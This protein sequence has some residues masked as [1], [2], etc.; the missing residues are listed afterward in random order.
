MET[1]GV[2]EGVV[3]FGDLSLAVDFVVVGVPVSGDWAGVFDG[4][5]NFDDSF[6]T[7]DF[8]VVAAARAG[9]FYESGIEKNS[10]TAR[11]GRMS[12]CVYFFNSGEPLEGRPVTIRARD[13][14]TWPD[15]ITVTIDVT[16]HM[17]TS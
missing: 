13:R 16:I 3:G 14:S 17:S 9:G 2:L 1:T 12:S 8:V 11:N 7:V 4:G 10:P 6:L 15:E 5:L